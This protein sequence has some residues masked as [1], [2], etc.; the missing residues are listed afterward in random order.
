MRQPA[1]HHFH[2]PREDGFGGWA[3]VLVP[4]DGAGTAI[5]L[6]LSQTHPGCWQPSDWRTL[7]HRE[8]SFSMPNSTC[9]DESA[10]GRQGSAPEVTP[11]A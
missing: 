8:G 2:Q 10:R 9:R 7:A 5:A 6:Q 1:A 3:K 11:L 4:P